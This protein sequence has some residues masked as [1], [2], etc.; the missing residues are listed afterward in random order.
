MLCFLLSLVCH[1]QIFRFSHAIVCVIIDRDDDFLSMD[2]IGCSKFY[3]LQ[4]S[5]C[6]CNVFFRLFCPQCFRAKMKFFISFDLYHLCRKRQRHLLEA[7]L[8]SCV[9]TYIVLIQYITIDATESSVGVLLLQQ[10]SFYSQCDVNHKQKLRCTYA[11]YGI[12]DFEMVHKI[13]QST[14]KALV[15]LCCLLAFEFDSQAL[16]NRRKLTNSATM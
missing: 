7:I 1:C 13:L 12:I 8:K 16:T 3:C 4:I 5:V 11:L 15:A 6:F 14:S 2:S 10:P 9:L